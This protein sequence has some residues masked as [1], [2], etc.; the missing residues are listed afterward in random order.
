[1]RIFSCHLA[2]REKFAWGCV[3]SEVCSKWTLIQL[4]CLSATSSTFGVTYDP[5]GGLLLCNSSMTH[6]YSSPTFDL[7]R[8]H[9]YIRLLYG[10]TYQH[11][12]HFFMH[13]D[14]CATFY[15]AYHPRNLRGF[16]S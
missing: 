1:M 6:L 11:F 10:S 7:I 12:I 14:M 8:L 4:V 15:H 2:G 3:G 16:W 5:F 9:Q 13:H